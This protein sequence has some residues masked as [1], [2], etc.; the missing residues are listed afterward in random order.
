[1]TI[2]EQL[3]GRIDR[4]ALDL[5]AEMRATAAALTNQIEESRRYT[6]VLHEDVL[7]RIRVIGE[8]LAVHDQ[9]INALSDKIDATQGENRAMFD[10]VISRL[11]AIEKRLPARRQK[12]R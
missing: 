11:T 2:L 5:R 6:R 10:T 3:P 8:G 7:D 1:M 4:L 12:N 9:N